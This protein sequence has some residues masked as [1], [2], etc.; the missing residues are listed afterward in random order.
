MTGVYA[1]DVDSY[2]TIKDNTGPYSTLPGEDI[3]VSFTLVNYELVTPR[4]VDVTFDPCPYGWDC[5]SKTFSFDTAG[6]HEVNLTLGVYRTARPAKYT[7]NLVLESEYATRRGYDRFIVTV[8]SEKEVNTLSVSEYLA[9]QEAAKNPVEDGP[10]YVPPPK[11][12]VLI[13]GGD[14]VGVDEASG[15]VDSEPAAEGNFAAELVSELPLADEASEII[16]NVGRLESSS[17]FVEY[18]SFVLAAV[19]MFLVVGAYVAFRPKK[20]EEK[21]K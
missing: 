11:P 21:N 12:T 17:Q 14:D 16:E 10:G 6:T 3:I 4:S 20:E 5:E 8:L 18:A 2:F 7:F 15:D 9:R 1:V 19:L 13:V